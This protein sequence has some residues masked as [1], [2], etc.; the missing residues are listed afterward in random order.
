VPAVAEPILHSKQAFYRLHL[1]APWSAATAQWVGHGGSGR[2]GLTRGCA[3]GQRRVRAIVKTKALRGRE[4]P[5]RWWGEC[6]TNMK[7][8]GF[9]RP[10]HGIG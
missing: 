1:P 7:A 9:E 5:A 2:L 3:F 8:Q 6:A 4:R 10:G